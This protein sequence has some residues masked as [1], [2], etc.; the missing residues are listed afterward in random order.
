MSETSETERI[1]DQHRRAF[2]GDAWHGPSVMSLITDV[3]AAQAASH[4]IV[5]AHSIWELVLHIAAWQRAG[6]RR[7]EGDP[8]QLTD[9]ENFPPVTDTSDDAWERTKQE[10]VD[11]HEALVE[12]IS[13]IKESRLDQA[14]ISDP[15]IPFSTTYV[16]LHGVVQHNLYHAGQIA[17]LK[18]A[19]GGS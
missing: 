13:A 8:A 18:K 4:P 5:S 15:S 17:L 6:N 19:L 1:V 2:A 11:T 10:L 3:T 12:K 7:L 16:T 9:E 14:I